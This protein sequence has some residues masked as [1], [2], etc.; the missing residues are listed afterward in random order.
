MFAIRSRN[1]HLI[2]VCFKTEQHILANINSTHELNRPKE[3]FVFWKVQYNY[4][5]SFSLS[6]KFELSKGFPFFAFVKKLQFVSTQSWPPAERD[7][8]GGV[9]RCYVT[10]GNSKAPLH[11]WRKA[12]LII[13]VGSLNFMTTK[14]PSLLY[15][16][17]SRRP[18]CLATRSLARRPAVVGGAGW[19]SGGCWSRYLCSTAADSCISFSPVAARDT[20]SSRWIGVRLDFNVPYVRCRLNL[21]SKFYLWYFVNL[22]LYFNCRHGSFTL[23][24]QCWF[25]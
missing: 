14:L 22:E 4:V 15:P 16:L 17:P 9:S 19:K 10:H 1:P 18:A 12:R 8:N 5:H 23:P 3:Q 25:L 13:Y 7:A 6:L 24:S 11:R 21:V 2:W 20:W